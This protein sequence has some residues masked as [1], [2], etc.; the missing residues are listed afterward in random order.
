[1]LLATLHDVTTPLRHLRL[2]P[3]AR[4]DG[5]DAAA[6]PAR[7]RAERYDAGLRDVA[8]RHGCHL[9]DLAGGGRPTR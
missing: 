4:V 5:V 8:R 9:L 3:A 6:A 7:R 1:M 2:P